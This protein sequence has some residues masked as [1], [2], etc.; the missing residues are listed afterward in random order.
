[1]KLYQGD[2]LEVMKT[3]P[4]N[5]IDCIITDPPYEFKDNG[6]GAGQAPLAKRALK[7]DIDNK[8]FSVSFDMEYLFETYY[9]RIL[10]KINFISF[11][12]ERMLNKYMT[13][14]EKNNLNYTVLVWHKTNPTPLCNNRYLN[15]IE[16]MIHI[17][18]K[19]VEIFGNYASKGK[20]Y[21][22]SINKKDKEI[23]NHPTIK[24]MALMEKLVFNHT[25][26]NDVVLDNFMGSGTTGVA[27]LKQDRDFIGIELDKE[28]FNIAKKRIEEAER[29][30]KSKLF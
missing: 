15:S 30:E 11:C 16:F 9:K 17:R 4:D 8:K 10:K 2:C 3:I 5:S 6:F 23:Y 13:Y 29:E 19:G 18:E 21:T 20:V 7:N 24:P 12:T 1:M 26:K 25:Q 28:Y 27:C 14:C 22:S